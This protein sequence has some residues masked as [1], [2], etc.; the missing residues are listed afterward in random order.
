ML[1]WFRIRTITLAFRRAR[2]CVCL[3]GFA[4]V[5]NFAH[6]RLRHPCLACPSRCTEPL[7][8][9]NH[10]KRTIIPRKSPSPLPFNQ[11]SVGFASVQSLWAFISGI[12]ALL[13]PPVASTLSISTTFS[14]AHPS[15]RPTPTPL[16][17]LSKVRCCRP[18][19]FVRLPEGLS[20]HQPFQNRTIPLA[21]RNAN[22]CMHQYVFT[23][24][25]SHENRQHPCLLMN[26]LLV[27]HP[28]ETL[29]VQLR[30]SMPALEKRGEVLLHGQAEPTMVVIAPH[31]HHQ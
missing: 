2:A 26:A 29:G 16:P 30:A 9:H 18:K 1:C 14:K 31:P 10:C 17:P 22:I 4:S 5:Q 3:Y 25:L 13:A 12:L 20:L 8:S 24:A 19:K 15:P 11:R 7:H 6:T 28:C 27:S 23:S 21:F